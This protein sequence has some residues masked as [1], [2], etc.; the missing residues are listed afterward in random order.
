MVK[1]YQ[2]TTELDKTIATNKKNSHNKNQKKITYVTE[3]KKHTGER[4]NALYKK[5]MKYEQI[6]LTAKCNNRLNPG[7]VHYHRCAAQN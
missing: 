7:L 2:N 1:T 6:S 4:K 3:Y 5:L